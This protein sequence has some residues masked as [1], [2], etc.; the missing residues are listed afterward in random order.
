MVTPSK[1]QAEVYRIILDMILKVIFS[2]VVIGVYIFIIVKFF[3]LKDWYLTF[4]LAGLEAFLTRTMYVA[5]K[6][7]FPNKD[8]ESNTES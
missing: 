3:T 7:Y 2:L 1:E 5:F 8:G 6:H 4:P